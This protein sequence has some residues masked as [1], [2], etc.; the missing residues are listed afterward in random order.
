MV[1]EESSEFMGGVVVHDE[2]HP[3]IA[4]GEVAAG[5]YPDELFPLHLALDCEC[6]EEFVEG[7]PE[8]GGKGSAVAILSGVSEHRVVY[9]H[10]FKGHSLSLI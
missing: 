8:F 9:G 10:R 7:F 4:I 6:C 2:T 5:C 1:I 3:D